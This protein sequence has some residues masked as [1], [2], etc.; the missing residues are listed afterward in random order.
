VQ[1]RKDLLEAH[2]LMTQRSAL[3]LI[4]GEPDSPNQ[5]LR[6]LN[7]GTISSV[8]V[9][10]IAAGVFAV[11]GLIAPGS[12]SGL[13]R[14]GTLVIDS[15]SATAYVPCA[16]GKLCPALNEASALLA[17]D[18]ASVRRV[19]A[20]QASLSHYSIGPTIGVAGLPQDLPA[21]GDL[22]SGP[23]AVCAASGVTT[24]VGGRSVGGT[25]LGVTS[26]ELAT[27]GQ[28]GDW[29]LW[30]GARLLIQP[31]VAQTLFPAMQVQTVPL[32]WLDALP[33][34]P[35][36][37]ALQIPGQG[38]VV[39]GPGGTPTTA[40]QVYGQ[41]GGG[42]AA[43]QYYVLLASGKLAQISA[44]QAQLLER[45]PGAPAQR[46][47]SPS[48]ATGDLSGTPIPP[49]GLPST[50]PALAPVTS[51]LCIRYGPGLQHQIITGGTVPAG[52]TPTEVSSAGVSSAGATSA[53]VTS[54]GVTSAGATSAGVSS[55]GATSA[56]VSSAGATSA[57]VSSAGATSPEASSAGATPAAAVS[58]VWLPP[59]HGAL[60]GAAPGS[61]ASGVTSYFLVTGATRYA[62]SSQGVAAVLGYDLKTQS[63]VLPAAL[64]DL[65]PTGPALNPAAAT[66][67]AASS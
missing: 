35:D 3:A 28:G 51:A 39:T 42:G 13:T 54:A 14:P 2:R 16:G 8:L 4:C 49:G 5:P 67:T 29:V 57:G 7:L 48:M 43:A 34:G 46:P 40:G 36:F 1:N 66:A 33:Q 10:A 53:G 61:T 62:L 21:A 55:A 44:T 37:T 20:S 27:T 17:L 23:W 12:A 26:A 45:E 52:A 58:Q 25:A 6:R 22:V 38:T 15:A 9:G 24:L 47:I 60:A 50:V 19:N 56:G 31:Q 11:L 32:A 30:N 63:T 59:A 18:S 64:L 41:P 65:L